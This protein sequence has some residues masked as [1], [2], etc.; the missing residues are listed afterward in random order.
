MAQRV[1]GGNK[2]KKIALK[3]VIDCTKPVD[4][5]VFSTS[6]FGDFLKSKI[7]VNGKTGHLGNDIT[8]SSDVKNVTVSASKRFF[9]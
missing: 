5:K 6:V 4:D 7:K 8:V 2:E 1:K 3:F 9:P